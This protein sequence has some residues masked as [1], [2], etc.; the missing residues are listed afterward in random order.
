MFVSTGVRIVE[1][2]RTGSRSPVRS[3]GELLRRLTRRFPEPTRHSMKHA[4][5]L[6]ILGLLLLAAPGWAAESRY[7]G[8]SVSVDGVGFF[9]NPTL[10]TIRIEKVVPNSPAAKLCRLYWLPPQRWK[11]HDDKPARDGRSIRSA[12]PM[13]ELFRERQNGVG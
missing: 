11:F 9:L 8:I 3:I 7:F 2:S 6:L 10:K 5:Q 12:I 13:D 1:Q 4:L